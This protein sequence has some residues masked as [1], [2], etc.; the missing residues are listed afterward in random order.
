MILPD[1]ETK[2]DMINNQAIAKTVVELIKESKER[3]I[4]IGIH[5]DWGA[6]KSSILE[7]VEDE[8]KKESKSK[9]AKYNVYC[10]KFNGWKHQGFEDA[11]IALMS[12]IVST[13]VKEKKLSEECKETIKKIWKNINW[14]SIA[15]STGSLAISTLTGNQP[16]NLLKSAMEIINSKTTDET[17]LNGIMGDIGDYLEKA[18]VFED[19]SLTNEFSEFQKSFGELLEKS[20]I[21][22]LVVLIDDLDRCLP[23][24]TIETL[25]AIRL[26]MFSKSTAFVIAA[27]EAMI[28]YAVKKH[29]PDLIDSNKINLGKDFANRYLEKLIQIPFRLPS[30]G[31]IESQMYIKLLF[32]SSKLENTKEDENMGKAYNKLLSTAID[33]MKKPWKN[34]G[35]LISDINDAL[36]TYGELVKEEIAISSQVAP[37]LSINTDGNPRKI[38]R[39]INMLLLRQKISFARGY[40]DEMQLSIMAKLMLAEH[41]FND[42]YREM[43][44]QTD[45]NG[46][47]ELT[48]KLENFFQDSEEFDNNNGDEKGK[49]I[50]EDSKNQIVNKDKKKKAKPN[51]DANLAKWM[52]DSELKKWVKSEPKLMNK[53]LRAYFFASKEGEE[54]IFKNMNSDTILTLIDQLMGG[55]M[56]VANIKE[57]IENLDNESVD[58]VFNI[59]VDKIFQQND[60]LNEPKGI[61]GI[62]ALITYHTEY[63]KKFISILNNSLEID[64]IGAW[65][66]KGWD[67]CITTS[68]ARIMWE[69]YQNRLKKESSPIIKKMLGS[70]V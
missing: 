46:I 59:I 52:E 11:K 55:K 20:K 67:S 2:V 56:N 19:S 60:F 17:E 47:C 64:K 58:T 32:I 41:F 33:K 10:I 30:L 70:E 22:K 24:V 48:N 1:N 29:F 53:D 63:Q 36:G 39:F 23:E 12:S 51:L 40:G 16:I 5:G 25:E 65:I 42:F 69:D 43:R 54:Y 13:L 49:E 50:K 3:P 38:K 66:C 4:S 44:R 14:L 8:F 31:D 68:E 57:K 6:G 62:K 45:S 18:K 7:M 37:I 27:D 28:Q 21:D 34:N 35:L 15:K 9:S 61:V 26:F